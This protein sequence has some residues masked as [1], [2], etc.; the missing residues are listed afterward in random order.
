MGE[1]KDSKIAFAIAMLGMGIGTIIIVVQVFLYLKDG[2]WPPV[3]LMALVPSSV[4]WQLRDPTDWIGLARVSVWLLDFVPLS[5]L[6]MG[7]SLMF[8]I[9]WHEWR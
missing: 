1:G 2:Q 9:Y 6:L 3:S 7:S 5:L 8:T 4:E